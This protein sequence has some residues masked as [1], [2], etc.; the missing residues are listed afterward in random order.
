MTNQEFAAWADKLF[1]A[2]PS[3]HEWLQGTYKPEETQRV[4]RATLSHF[5]FDECISVVNRWTSGALEPFAA[6]DRDKV[7]LF[8][9]AICSADRDRAGKK[10][11]QETMNKPYY[12]RR[13]S[14]GQH[15]GTGSMMDSSMA[16]AVAEGAIQQRRLRDGEISESEYYTL[17]EEITDKYRIG[18]KFSRVS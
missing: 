18:P 6:Y 16:A 4:W 11:A 5:T 14:S 15:I 1:V 3:L 10:K 8:V 2:F 7:H 9:R 13:V 12:T 17:R